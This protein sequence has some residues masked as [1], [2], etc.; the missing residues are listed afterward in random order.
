MVRVSAAVLISRRSRGRAPRRQLAPRE[1]YQPP[2]SRLAIQPG[3]PPQ[4]EQE[5]GRLVGQGCRQG[6]EVRLAERSKKGGVVCRNLLPCQP[7]SRAPPQHVLT[8]T[9]AVTAQ[10]AY[11]AIFRRC[12]RENDCVVR[13]VLG[14]SRMQVP[15]GISG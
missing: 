3:M 9:C 7:H 5:E 2:G 6:A 10:R 11:L 4:R 14:P 8:V 1:P 15:K 12:C 13:R